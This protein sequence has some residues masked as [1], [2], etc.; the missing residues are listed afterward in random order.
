M[1]CAWNDSWRID[2]VRRRWVFIAAAIL[3]TACGGDGEAPF[4]L[5]ITNDFSTTLD[6]AALS[7]SVSLPA[8]SE[9]A[10]GTV[11]MPYLTCQLGPH[12]MTWSNSANGTSGAV[13]VMWD[14]PKDHASWSAQ[15]IPLA[16]GANVVTVTVSD[17][18]RTAQAAVT[19]T[20]E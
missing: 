1:S 6:K 20:R 18:S 5:T 8:D 13:S 2:A 3:L 19:V 11:T 10:G 9:R 7:G 15:T 14:C 16:M 17:S 12:S 4:G